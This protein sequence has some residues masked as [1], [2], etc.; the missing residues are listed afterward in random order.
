MALD[1]DIQRLARV[2]LFASLEREALRLIAFAAER[3]TFADGD[4][5]FRAGEA[6]DCGYFLLSGQVRVTA[7][8]RVQEAGEDSLIGEMALL[9]ELPRPA[10]ARAVGRVEVMRITRQL[11][12]RVL[13]EFPDS[14]VA[15]HKAIAA[16]VSLLAGQLDKVRRTTIEPRSY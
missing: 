3:Q 2:P 5:L 1:N 7:G 11:V 4:I 10:E 8:W 9:A 13:R 12:A 16:R 15:L 14:A 6:A